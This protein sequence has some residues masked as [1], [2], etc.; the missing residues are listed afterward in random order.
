MEAA[1]RHG[2]R[3]R[4]LVRDVRRAERLLPGVELVRGDLEDPVSL[5]SAA[6]GAGAIVL[7]HG[8]G[9]HPDTRRRVDYG[10]VRDLL[11]ALDGA[12][13]RR[14]VL[15]QGGTAAGRIGSLTR[16]I[17][18]AALDAVQLDHLA[19]QHHRPLTRTR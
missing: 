13:Q 1:Q 7:S 16:L 3:P 17:R 15:E 11:Q 8:S 10:G 2:L 18:Q 6:G 19:E 5:R 4:A 12:T 14:L 9:S